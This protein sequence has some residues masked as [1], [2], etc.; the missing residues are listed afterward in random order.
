MGCDKL[1]MAEQAASPETEILCPE[2]NVKVQELV[3]KELQV[4]TNEAD[5][6]RAQE[7]EGQILRM[8][9]GRDAEQ[10]QHEEAEEAFKQQLVMERAIAEKEFKSLKDKLM[11]KLAAER[12][13]W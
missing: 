2:V 6:Q 8:K 1:P 9:Q 12:A 11:G 4:E 13:K 5:K 7:L 3:A 10:K